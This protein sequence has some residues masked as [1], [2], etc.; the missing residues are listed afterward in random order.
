MMVKKVC[1][2]CGRQFS[3]DIPKGMTEYERIN[4]NESH[5]ICDGCAGSYRT[6]HR[7][8]NKEW[9]PSRGLPEDYD[10]KKIGLGASESDLD[11]G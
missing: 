7:K 9:S 1:E 8:I 5:R 6:H 10:A 2:T 11:E 4:W 3:A